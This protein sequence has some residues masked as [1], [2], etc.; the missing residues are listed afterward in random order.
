MPFRAASRC[1]PDEIPRAKRPLADVRSLALA[2]PGEII[3]FA[4]RSNL[5]RL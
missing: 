4:E 3:E 5:E 1:D 2:R